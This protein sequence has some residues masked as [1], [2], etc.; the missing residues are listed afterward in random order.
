MFVPLFALPLAAQ[1]IAVA[2]G[3][4]KLERDAE[5]PGRGEVRLH[6]DRRR[7]G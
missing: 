7:A 4:P 5:L 2:D 6:R 1:L 3:V